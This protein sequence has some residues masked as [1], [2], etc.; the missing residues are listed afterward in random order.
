MTYGL[1]WTIHNLIPPGWLIAGTL[2]AL[3]GVSGAGYVNFEECVTA[4]RT[5]AP[6]EMDF[7]GGQLGI[8]NNDYPLY[9]NRAGIDGRN[10]TW[11]LTAL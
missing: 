1:D 6:I 3:P 9:D 10:P 5:F 2:T 11:C 8:W 4:S 7:A